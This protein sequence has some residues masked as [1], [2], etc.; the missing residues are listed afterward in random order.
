VNTVRQGSYPR[1]RKQQL[2]SDGKVNE[3]KAQPPKKAMLLHPSESGRDANIV[4]INARRSVA[5]ISR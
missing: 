5:A 3:P 2:E 1:K 4:S